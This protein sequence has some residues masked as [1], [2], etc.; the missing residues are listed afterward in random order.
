MKSACFIAASLLLM[1]AGPVSG[2]ENPKITDGTGAF[3]Q[4]PLNLSD[5]WDK[6]DTKPE[7]IVWSSLG[8]DAEAEAESGK[9]VALQLE[10]LQSGESVVLADNL[11]GH[12]QTY[13]WTPQNIS[14]QV[15]VLRHVVSKGSP[16]EMLT[17]RFSFENYDDLPPAESD[18]RL[19]IRPAD[20]FGCAYD[21]T[22]DEENW[23]SLIGG[24]GEGIAAPSGTSEFLFALDGNGTLS[25][26]YTLGGGTWTVFVDDVQVRTLETAVDWEALALDCGGGKPHTIRFVTVLSD[27]SAFARLRNV[28][29]TEEDWRSAAGACA[30]MAVDLRTN[31]VRVIRYGEMLPFTYSSTNFTGDAWIKST[32]F[33][34]IADGSVASVRVVQVTGE[35]GDVSQW[36]TEVA[37][38]E[39]VLVPETPGEGCVVWKK[40]I[41]RAVWKAEFTIKTSGS[42]VHTE[43]SILD[44]RKYRVGGMLIFLR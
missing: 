8:W 35:G 17:A 30:E 43:T 31:A 18:V 4:G 19:A 23:W 25:F 13:T 32:G 1:G 38:T 3:V 14:K 9:T 26:D 7:P 40:G 6:R 39:Q 29:W 42:V 27:E 41:M 36:M 37:S 34:K 28:R 2:P 20:R 5:V 10:Q 22:N 12:C 44:L 15:C 16:M 24:P 33:K 11:V 21:F